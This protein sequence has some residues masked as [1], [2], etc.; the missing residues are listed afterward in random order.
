MTAR[1]Y[2]WDQAKGGFF[3]T[4]TDAEALIA[5]TKQAHDSPNPSGNGMMTGVLARLFFLTGNPA[6]RDQAAELVRAFAGEARR[7]VF[8]HGALFN[9]NELLLRGLQI[10]IRGRRGDAGTA[11]LLGAVNGASLPNLVLTL[12]TPDRDLP[13]DHPAAGKGQIG[14]KAT[15]YLC[16]GPVCSLPLTDAAALAAA[17]REK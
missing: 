10:V 3:F 12:L 9:G 2:Y 6:Y 13:A 4:A 15:V 8:G 17:L 14:G 16:K 1:L 5:R 11:A 7:S